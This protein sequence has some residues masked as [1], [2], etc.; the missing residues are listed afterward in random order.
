MFQIL[1]S[2]SVFASG[3]W[4]TRQRQRPLGK[5][6]WKWY[7]VSHC[8]FFYT[9][10]D[11][12]NPS[13][14]AA[15]LLLGLESINASKTGNQTEQERAQAFLIGN[16]YIEKAFNANQ[17]SAAAA[18]ALCELFLRKNNFKRA[19]LRFGTSIQLF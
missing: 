11:D 7:V 2:V 6:V 8:V 17:K 4:I 13:E 14:S 15:Q 19:S 12:Q 9:L 10:P 3:R 16:K 1:E 18:N 5:E